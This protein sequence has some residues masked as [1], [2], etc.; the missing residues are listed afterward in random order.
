MDMMKILICDDEGIVQESLKFMIHKSFGQECQTEAA[1]N[2]RIAI[3]LAETFRPDIILMDIQMPGI[4]GIE[5]MQEIRRENKNVV[6]IVLTAYDKFEYTQRSIDIGVL[7]YLTKPINR[8]LLT[9]TLR[10]AMIKVKHRKEKASHDLKVRE[11]LEAVIPIIESGFVYSVLLEG[12]G[13]EENMGYQELLNL[14]TA[15]GY[16]MVIE[17]GDE[18]KQG[19][20]ANTLGAG[21]KLQKHYMVFRDI[22]KETTQGIIGTV[23]ANKVIVLVPCQNLEEEYEERVAKID[24]TRAL[25][26]KL[27]QQLEL[28]F[29]AGIG[30]VK[31]WK[32]MSESYQEALEIVR[33][34]VGKVAHVKDMPVSCIYEES[35]PNELEGD[36]FKAFKEGDEGEIRSLAGQFVSWMESNVPQ[37]NN[38]VRLKIME[39]ILYGEHLAYKSGCKMYRFEDR[40]GYLE[41]LLSIYTYEELSV[42]FVNKLLDA[43]RQLSSRKQEKTASTVEKAKEYI[44]QNFSSELSLEEMA[45]KVGISPYYLS[46]LFKEAEGVNYIDYVTGLRIEYAK[47]CLM[48]SEK[49]IKEICHEAGYSDPNYFS[50]IFKKWAG[51]TPTEYRGGG[52]ES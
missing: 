42:W 44:N 25:L 14:N 18:L 39:F 11:K 26:R 23:M 33:Q 19:I 36:L 22:V 4:N 8:D 17:C 43:S 47:E 20:L 34:G 31:K 24:R 29:K 32:R 3:E 52:E 38:V 28:K 9:E 13:K 35:Y 10:K 1:K 51:V 30:S 2:G 21:I 49:S 12:Y 45:Q 6:F 37:L 16:A 48:Q 7:A 5:A 27:E 46:K 50:R 41:T 40:Q 15:Y